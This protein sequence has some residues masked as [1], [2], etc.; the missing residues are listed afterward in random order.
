M[1]KKIYDDYRTNKVNVFIWLRK[2]KYATLPED[3]FKVD[4][5]RFAYR[6][7]CQCNGEDHVKRHMTGNVHVYTGLFGNHVEELSWDWGTLMLPEQA[8]N[9]EISCSEYKCLYFTP[10]MREFLKKQQEFSDKNP[11]VL[12]EY[13]SKVQT[14]VNDGQ[15]YVFEAENG[16]I[17]LKPQDQ[18][19]MEHLNGKY[20]PVK[21]SEMTFD[22]NNFINIIG[23]DLVGENIK[24]LDPGADKEYSVVEVVESKFNKALR[25]VKNFF[26]RKKVDDLEVMQTNKLE[27]TT[28][29]KLNDITNSDTKDNDGK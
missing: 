10:I 7:L 22:H 8:Q 3:I 4:E 29:A 21:I 20:P 5:K 11:D 19:I 12:N 14:W 9:G 25:G 24:K 6:V 23:Q 1:S 16:K 15:I 28:E 13:V 2:N 17:N 26:L 27:S 18:N